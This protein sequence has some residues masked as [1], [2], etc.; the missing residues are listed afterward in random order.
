MNS[1]VDKFVKK[2]KRW[3]K[4]IE[5]VRSILL[6]TDLEEN[7]KWN[8]PCYSY[9]GSNVLII[10]PFKSYLGLMFFKGA[11]LKD[12][13]GLL[14][15]PGPNSQAARRFEFTSVDQIKKLE[16]TIKAYIKE[17]IAIEKS[18]KKVE[19]KKKPLSMPSELKEAFAKKPALKKAF[20]SLTPGRQRAYILYFSSA[21]QSATRQAR[22]AKC[23]PQIL[24]G[25]G[26]NDR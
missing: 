20:E 17:A 7:L 3:Q 24:K 6:K 10:Q 21:K 14:A 9:E 12:P 18:G 19:V 8:L 5:K 22:I 2:V 25:K 26:L 15:A 13:K 23:T 11:L 16:P 4:E 1:A